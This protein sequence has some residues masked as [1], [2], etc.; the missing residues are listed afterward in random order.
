MSAGD[1]LLHVI[2]G[3]SHSKVLHSMQS[4]GQ[5]QILREQEIEIESKALSFWFASA[6]T[7]DNGNIILT[8]GRQTPREAFIWSNLGIWTRLPKLNHGRY[9]HSSCSISHA[10][11]EN[12]IVAGGWDKDGTKI[13]SSVEI[14]QLNNPGKG[15]TEIQ[16]LVSPR[17]LFTLQVISKGKPSYCL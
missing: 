11:N 16:S 15:W 1:S 4:V 10:D 6:V 13:Q 17:T 7:L 8:G 2:G 5:S 9:G 12:V 3:I 14:Y